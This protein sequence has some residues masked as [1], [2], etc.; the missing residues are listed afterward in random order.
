[1][2]GYVLLFATFRITL[3]FVAFEGATNLP[4]TML[5][6]PVSLQVFLPLEGVVTIFDN[7]VFDFFFTVVVSTLNPGRAV[8]TDAADTFPDGAMDTTSNV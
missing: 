3:H 2:A 4:A 6:V 7:V 1:M 8:N 5:H